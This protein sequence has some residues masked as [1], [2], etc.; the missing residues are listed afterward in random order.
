MIN[1]CNSK[2]TIYKFQILSL[3]FIIIL[4]QTVLESDPKSKIKLE[5]QWDTMPIEL[6]P[7]Y[8]RTKLNN[9]NSGNKKVRILENV[10]EKFKQLEE[11]EKHEGVEEKTTKPSDNDDEDKEEDENNE[12]EDEEMDDE[13]DYGNN[14]FDNGE[15]F[16]EEDDNLDDGP[17]Y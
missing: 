12:I 4:F 8:K 1:Y 15:A 5:F 6:R 10:E 7:S 17:V 9:N 3:N 11:K 2:I 16:N 14:Y 13:N